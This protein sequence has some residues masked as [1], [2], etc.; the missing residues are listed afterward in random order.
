MSTIQAAAL[1]RLTLR[2]RCFLRHFLPYFSVGT[3]MQV[4]LAGVRSENCDAWRAE[5]SDLHKSGMADAWRVRYAPASV[6]L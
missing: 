6:Y 5:G 1:C 2:V 3:I 4:T